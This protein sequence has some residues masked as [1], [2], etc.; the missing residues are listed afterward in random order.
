MGIPL[1]VSRTDSTISIQWT[2]LTGINTGNS[3]ITAYNL[4]WDTVPS[5]GMVQLMPDTLVTTYSVTGLTSSQSYKFK[6]RAK[7]IYGHGDFSTEATFEASDKPGKPTIP[8]VVLDGVNVKV[9][10]LKPAENG[11][12]ID[13]YEVSF[14]KLDGTFAIDT[15]NCNAGTDPVFSAKTCSIPMIS[16]PALTN[17]VVD[18]L[19][20]ARVRAKNNNGF[21]E[22]S[23]KN[24]VG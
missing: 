11:S 18:T 24:T 1:E 21:G 17:L 4:Y 23:E 13:G 2:A 9:T 16:I 3:A 12:T 19:I 14:K 22:Y 5:T 10:W 20:Q 6:V 8:S 15:T 7:N